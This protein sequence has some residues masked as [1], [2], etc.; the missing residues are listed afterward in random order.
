LT[1]NTQR[2]EFDISQFISTFRAN[3]PLYASRILEKMH[4]ILKTPSRKDT[5]QETLSNHGDTLSSDKKTT[6]VTK[7]RTNSAFEEISL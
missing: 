2:P 7:E 5:L 1:S 6:F 3:P 4:S